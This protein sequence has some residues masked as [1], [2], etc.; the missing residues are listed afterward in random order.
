MDNVTHTLVGLATGELIHRCLPVETDAAASRVRRRL[1]LVSCAVA[2][3]FPDLD[4]ILSPLLPAPL[5][6][7]LHHRGHTHTI[8]YAIPQAFLMIAVIWF[9]WKSAREAMRSS[10]DVRIGLWLSTLIGFA[11]HLS[12]DSLNTYGI[13]P[14]HPIDSHWYFGDMIFILE[15]L[16]WA[17][18]GG[19]L[20]VMIEK[21]KYKWAVA[22]F[23]TGVPAL[24]A[25]QGFL[26]WYSVVAIAVTMS[27][28][29]YL[30]AKSGPKKPTSLIAAAM[31]MLIFI[32]I[33]SFSSGQAKRALA[34][35]L[36]KDAEGYR[37]H[38]VA[39]SPLPTNPFCWTFV[40]VESKESENLY[41]LRKGVISIASFVSTENC[42]MSL[43]REGTPLRK[44]N[45]LEILSN[46]SGDLARLRELKKSNCFFEAWLRFA[47]SPFVDSAQ[48]IDLRFSSGLR[49]NFTTLS[50]AEFASGRECPS[51]IPQW[52]FP[53]ADLLGDEK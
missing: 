17:A 38:D 5:G 9:A 21:K 25:F 23:L 33:Q 22:A 29:G 1:L 36:A 26:A 41:R 6:Y 49:A 32:A 27:T 44:T 14:F 15:P 12:M 40:S 11:L 30:E 37:L 19:P 24:L 18:C 51:G 34:E 31:V 45:G 28:L 8:L 3:N 2:S 20:L 7:L 10:I 52:E 4:L 35:D 16:F 43:F 53:R 39:A 48:A 47:R 13:H 42:P 46:Q 50:L